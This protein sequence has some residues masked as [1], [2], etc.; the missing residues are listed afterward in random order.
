MAERINGERVH[1]IVAEQSLASIRRRPDNLV[2]LEAIDRIV[3]VGSTCVGKST[4][5]Q[6]IR[7]A[8]LEHPL[9]R[10]KI[11]VPQRVATRPQRSD[12]G[13]MYFC[14]PDKFHK[15]V[16]SDEL[17]LHG[18]KIME[19]GRQEP[20][21]YLKPTEGTLPIFFANNQTLRH[22]V[23]VRPDGILADALI[24]LIYAPDQIRAARLRER[25]PELFEERPD[26]VA[27]RLSP[28]ERAIGLAYDV[29]L[30]LK[31]FGRFAARSI[32]DTVS[33]I[34]G[35]ADFSQP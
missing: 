26:E 14:T 1:T 19:G 18:V 4:L 5:E 6:A 21:G 8:S 15:M 2:A 13:D 35:I 3:L 20:Y 32:E 7:A 30:I 27:F 16:L 31:N 12:D 28:A 23:S 9:L 24:I 11:S 17:G 22:R 25:S 33:L 34:K 10:G 29:H